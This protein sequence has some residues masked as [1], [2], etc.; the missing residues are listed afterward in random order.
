MSGNIIVQMKCL[1][2]LL[3]VSLSV[4]EAAKAQACP[5]QYHALSR[6]VLGKQILLAVLC[7][8]DRTSI[9]FA[10]P[11]LSA[12]LG[13][14]TAD[15]GLGAGIFFIGYTIFQVWLKALFEQRICLQH[16]SA[17]LQWPGLP[18]HMLVAV[19]LCVLQSCRRM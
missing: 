13:F 2:K 6:H 5:D 18:S 19:V 1:T 17:M 7:Y 3:L 11:Q 12:Q 4:M 10:A 8:I 16:S 14:S 15:Y 9:S